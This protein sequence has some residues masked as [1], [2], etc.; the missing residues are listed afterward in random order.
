MNRLKDAIGQPWMNHYKLSERE[1]R[2]CRSFPAVLV[3]RGLGLL[4]GNLYAVAV[5]EGKKTGSVRS[6][7][8]QNGRT[9][10][11][12]TPESIQRAAIGQTSLLPPAEAPERTQRPRLEKSLATS[13]IHPGRNTYCL[14]A[15]AVLGSI[16][17]YGRYPAELEF[18]L[19]VRNSNYNYQI[20][21]LWETGQLYGCPYFPDHQKG[22]VPKVDGVA[23]WSGHQRRQ[24][25]SCRP[26]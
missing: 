6:G 25:V 13:G 24:E 16:E 7:A 19:H 20:E 22:D 17:E 23:A 9:I 2:V 26:D 8:S 12:S 3:G 18:E 10:D 11:R 15:C 21:F 4:F 1:R 14:P 5:L